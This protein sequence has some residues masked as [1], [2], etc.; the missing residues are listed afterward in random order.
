MNE[1]LLEWVNAL[2]DGTQR[3]DT[4]EIDSV[5]GIHRRVA[6]LVGR[7]FDGERDAADD[8]NR[9]VYRLFIER[10]REPWRRGGLDCS[11]AAVGT[12]LWTFCREW[13]RAGIERHAAVLDRVPAD[14]DEFLDWSTAYVRDH[15][16]NVTHPL[17]HYLEMEATYEEL[18]EFFFQETPFDIHFAD[19]L[20]SLLAGIHGEPKMEIAS[21]FWDEMGGGDNLR[22]HRN[23][24][25]T[26]MRALDL[27]SDAHTVDVNAFI[28]EE[29]ELA[30]G[31]FVGTFDRSKA[32]FL[33]GMLLATEVMVPGR[34]QRQISGWRRVGLGDR[35][36]D[37]LLEHTVVDIEHAD[38]WV[39]HVIRPVLNENPGATAALALGIASRLEL[40]G[41]V[42]DRMLTHL[43]VQRN[44]IGASMASR[45]RE[46][47]TGGPDP[48]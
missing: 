36:M 5:G 9:A 45:S 42:C 43:P 30:N 28:L 27:P 38:G 48:S 11:H 29:I 7:A 32:L 34:L 39:D 1:S 37:Y 47:V 41:A 15:R 24:R 23:L 17:F 10:Y 3:V 25:L 19:I 6:E 2:C 46:G 26:M 44:L 20:C 22:A 13:E 18:R 16:S 35:D 8:L 31:Y 40:A 14:P 4:Y 21:N 12:V 33:L